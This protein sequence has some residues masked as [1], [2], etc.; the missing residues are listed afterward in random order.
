MTQDAAR[1]ANNADTRQSFP[2]SSFARRF[3]PGADVRSR[4]M[5]HNGLD[6]ILRAC[7]ERGSPGHVPC[8]VPRWD[9]V[10]MTNGS[11]A[12]AARSI[13]SLAFCTGEDTEP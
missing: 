9:G 7:R 4:S 10:S 2:A 1:P 6:P 13:G 5:I 8:I 12:P 11:G 3:V